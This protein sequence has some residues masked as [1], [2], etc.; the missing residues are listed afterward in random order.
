[1]G[2]RHDNFTYQSNLMAAL[3]LTCGGWVVAQEP[4]KQEPPKKE[5]PAPEEQPAPDQKPEDQP[6]PAKPDQTPAGSEEQPAEE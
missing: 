1:M 2:I 5:C 3:M 4:E 6:E